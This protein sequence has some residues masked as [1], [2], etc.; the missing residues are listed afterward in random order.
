MM[1]A[2]KRI[3]GIE[4]AIRAYR[5]YADRQGSILAAA[6]TYYGFLS[7]FPLL[8]LAFAGVG[9]VA[10]FLPGAQ[11]ALDASLQ[12]LLPGMIGE[13]PDQISLK[14]IKDSAGA[15]AGLGLVTVAYAGLNWIAEMRDALAAMFEVESSRKPTSTRG[16]VTHFIAVRVRDGLVLLTI[17]LVLL[18]SVAISGGVLGL[19]DKVASGWGVHAQLGFVTST[20]LIVAGAATGVVLFFAMFRLLANPTESNR[21]LWSGA[22][23]GALGFELLKQV[24]KWLLASTTH[25]PAFQAFGIALILL[26]WIYYFSRVIMFAA[27][28]A[29]TDD[30]PAD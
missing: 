17:G 27:A 8:A 30:V 19:I 15:V 23:L 4:H 16:R 28:W 25:Q 20:I 1:S 26:V 24:S 9:L 5:H 3:P 29:R 13:G 22:L 11:R 12:S 6:V 18:S 21:S 2:L 14:A 7:L 10:E